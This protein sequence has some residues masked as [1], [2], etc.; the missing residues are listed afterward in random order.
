FMRLNIEEPDTKISKQQ[1][2]TIPVESYGGADN[3]SRIYFRKNQ[4][5]QKRNLF[6]QR[7]VVMGGPLTVAA[8]IILSP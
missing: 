7:R 2:Y 3:Q 4:T 6:L 1:K 8:S 5:Q